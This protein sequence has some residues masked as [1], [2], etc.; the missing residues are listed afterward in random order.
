METQVNGVVTKPVGRRNGIYG[1]VVDRLKVD[2]LRDAAKGAGL[3]VGEEDSAEWLATSLQEFYKRQQAE[4]KLPLY[5]CEVKAGGCGADQPRDEGACPFCGFDPDAKAKVD[6]AQ[7]LEVSGEDAPQEPPTDITD[8]EKVL[9]DMSPVEPRARKPRKDKGPKGRLSQPPPMPADAKGEPVEEMLPGGAST[10]LAKVFPAELMVKATDDTTP[11]SEV[12]T[13]RD[14]DDAIGR[15]WEAN[16]NSMIAWWHEGQLM[17]EIFNKK[18]WTLRVDPST[19]GPKYKS[20]QQFVSAEIK[21]TPNYVF[22]RMKAARA[23]TEDRAGKLGLANCVLILRVPEDEKRKTL[24]EDV[25]KGKLESTRQ[26]EKEVRR[27]NKGRQ[28]VKTSG[29][30]T[31]ERKSGGGRKKEIIKV[32]IAGYVGKQ[33]LS[34]LSP[35]DGGKAVKVTEVPSAVAKW[36]EKVQPFAQHESLDGEVVETIAIVVKDGIPKLVIHRERPSDTE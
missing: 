10:G 24:E 4:K 18:L 13:A 36:L 21:F 5:Q 7:G 19:K 20:F 8:P 29:S 23:Y 32:T 9:G 14:L 26:T 16:R 6:I 33:T 28:T 11:A 31:G 15:F 25:I 27:A 17:W 1:I 22:D 34:F 2:S 12:L 35:S 30:K 3:A